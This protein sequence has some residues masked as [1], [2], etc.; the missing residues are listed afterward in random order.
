MAVKVI[1]FGLII[2]FVASLR[3]DCNYI[4]FGGTESNTIIMKGHPLNKCFGYEIV[5]DN[6][7]YIGSWEFNCNTN[8]TGINMMMYESTDCDPNTLTETMDATTSVTFPGLNI[9]FD[10][11]SWNCM[12]SNDC[13]YLEY[14]LHSAVPVPPYFCY[15]TDSFYRAAYLS[16]ACINFTNAQLGTYGSGYYECNDERVSWKEYLT[17]DTCDGTIYN[18]G[19]FSSEACFNNGNIIY[20]I[21]HCPIDN[22]T[23]KKH[24]WV[25]VFVSILASVCVVAICAGVAVYVK[26][27]RMFD[28]MQFNGGDL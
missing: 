23:K 6:L 17:S 27:R 18:D 2:Y 26:K 20:E 24:K 10:T 28:Y 3:N 19:S 9:T 8:N 16:D 12:G 25:V 13:P 21:D 14:S 1:L 7:T 5:S 22:E 11:T 4:N 15:K